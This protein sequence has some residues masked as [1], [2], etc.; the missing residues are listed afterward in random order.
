ML[1]LTVLCDTNNVIKKHS[2]RAVWNSKIRYTCEIL[3]FSFYTNYKYFFLHPVRRTPFATGPED[4]PEIILQ[5]IGEGSISLTGGTWDNVT[6]VA[7]VCFQ[8]LFWNASVEFAWWA[9]SLSLFFELIRV[10]RI[11]LIWKKFEI[12][13]HVNYMGSGDQSFCSK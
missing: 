6:D 13:R 8:C 1:S 11:C 9:L 2:S 12:K 4:R 7:K 3:S 5:R 10:K